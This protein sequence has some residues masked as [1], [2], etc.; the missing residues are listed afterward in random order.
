MSFRLEAALISISLMLWLTTLCVGLLW[1]VY[2]LGIVYFVMAAPIYLGLWGVA[3]H[4]CYTYWNKW[5][6]EK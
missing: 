1:F 5:V 3:A 2:S 6:K 4:E